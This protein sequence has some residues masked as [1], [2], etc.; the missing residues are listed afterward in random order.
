MAER[1]RNDERVA[2]ARV[3]FSHIRE[4]GE[5][6]R[7]IASID[8]DERVHVGVAMRHPNDRNFSRKMG[9]SIAAGRARFALAR[10]LGLTAREGSP[11]RFNLSTTL[12]RNEF[13]GFAND[14][15]LNIEE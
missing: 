15:G 8:D 1:W 12:G 11:S 13:A 5:L 2:N 7:T 4:D 6:T 9:R 10:S 3:R 14:L